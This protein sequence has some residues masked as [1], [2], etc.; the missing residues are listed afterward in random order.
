MASKVNIGVT[1]HLGDEDLTPYV[2]DFPHGGYP[3]VSM[4]VG[5]VSMFIH[6]TQQARALIE[7]AQQA[8]SYLALGEARRDLANVAGLADALAQVKD[9]GNA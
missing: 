9:A 2:R 6:T 8:L 7:G 3:F 1:V 5:D 4:D